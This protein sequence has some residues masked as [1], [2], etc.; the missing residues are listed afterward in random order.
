MPFFYSI[1]RPVGDTGY[2]VNT[3]EE[4]ASFNINVQ[5]QPNNQWLFFVG[6][7]VA[8]N[9]S[10]GLTYGDPKRDLWRG[11]FT[12]SIGTHRIPLG[13]GR[14]LATCKWFKL[15]KREKILMRTKDAGIDHEDSIF[16]CS[17]ST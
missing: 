8:D 6:W 10:F 15:P 3:L 17:G 14:H 12:T 2:R 13:A 4:G 7:H 11:R 16:C 9:T 5:Y 1:D